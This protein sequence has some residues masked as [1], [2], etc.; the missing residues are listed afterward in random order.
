MKDFQDC[1]KLVQTSPQ[2]DMGGW[3]M[4]EPNDV[5]VETAHLDMLLAY[6]IHCDKPLGAFGSKTMATDTFEMAKMVGLETPI[7]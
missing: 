2:L 4:V 1:C 5:P 7:I 3:L 6:F